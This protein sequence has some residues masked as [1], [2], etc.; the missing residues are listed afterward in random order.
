MPIQPFRACVSG[1]RNLTYDVREITLRL[2][3]P[4][5]IAFKAG[6]FIS[7]EVVHPRLNQPVTRPYSIAS[8]PSQREQVTLLLNLVPNGPGSTYLFSLREGD[9][10]QFKGVTGSFYLRDEDERDFLFVATG[11]GIAPIRSMLYDLLD[12]NFP[13]SITLFWGLRSQ[14]DLYY[15]DELATLAKRFA[16]FTAVATLS[17]PE[18]GWHGEVGRVTTLVE[19]RIASVKN[20]A[21]Y[22]CGSS[23]MLKDVSEIVNKKGLCPIRR[24]KWYDDAGD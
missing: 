5:Q 20:L 23:G 2:L 11:T 13:R 14:K 19:D 24:E 3:E 1:I 4:G 10:T 18:N 7:F 17:R 22:L 21:V 12:K 16:S 9:E 6:Q 8:P 15:Q